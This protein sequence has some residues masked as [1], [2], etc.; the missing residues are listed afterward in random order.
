MS[1][2]VLA[3]IWPAALY[4]HGNFTRMQVGRI[5]LEEGHFHHV[6]KER[7]FKVRSLL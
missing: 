2:P 6:L 7:S 3:Q 1:G 5:L 4:G